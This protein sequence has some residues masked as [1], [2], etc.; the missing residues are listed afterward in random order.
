MWGCAKFLQW[1]NDVL[2]T[3]TTKGKR[4]S[5]YLRTG[6]NF[7]NH[8]ASVVQPETRQLSSQRHASVVQPETR[9][10]SGSRHVF[11]LAADTSVVRPETRQL[12]G[13]RHASCP[14]RDTSVVRQ[15]TRRVSPSNP[16]CKFSRLS[17]SDS[18]NIS[19]ERKSGISEKYA[20]LQYASGQ[21]LIS[22]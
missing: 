21:L 7:T 14:A 3:T 13:Q 5:A 8:G 15:Q 10:L 20:M 4:R 2:R 18:C 1:I 11:C 16:P 19:E 6:D 17:H 9:Q 12:S 22:T